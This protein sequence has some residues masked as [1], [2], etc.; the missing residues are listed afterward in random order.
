MKKENVRLKKQ[1]IA[2]VM[3]IIIAINPLLLLFIKKIA[4]KE[5]EQPNNPQP[6]IPATTENKTSPELIDELASN[7]DIDFNEMILPTPNK[8]CTHINDTINNENLY[9]KTIEL[10]NTIRNNSI[11]YINNNKEYTL[12]F[13]DVCDI[14]NEHST[15]QIMIQSIFKDSISDILI[16]GT[17]KDLCVLKDLKVIISYSSEFNNCIEYKK[18]DNLIIIHPNNNWDEIKY[19]IKLELN[20]I[21]ID[22]CNCQDTPLFSYS[23]LNNASIISELYNTNK[24]DL[25]VSNDDI[26]K[27]ALFLT[28]GLFHDNYTVDDYYKTIFNNDIEAL[29]KF[30]GANNEEDIYIIN[31]ILY[32]MN[33]NADY[34]YKADIYSIII[35]NLINYTTNNPK[36]TL[37]ENLTIF[38]SLRNLIESDFS[39]N[40]EELSNKYIKFLSKHYKKTTTYIINTLNDNNITNY[41]IAL[42]NVCHEHNDGNIEI[43]YLNQANKL[44]KTFPLL[45]NILTLYNYQNNNNSLSNPFILSKTRNI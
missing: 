35:N 17:S 21:R 42:Y 44:L 12:G 24:T 43:R 5:A 16:N 3:S 38:N 26:K 32:A 9:N 13:L 41:T 28:L 37:K 20:K 6:I 4:N 2:Y 23:T 8:K 33:T 11:E 7:L 27:E 36:F 45:K 40:I 31:K 19:A 18:E 39:Q 22:N 10:I 30:C 25:F 34:N 29:Y 14:D 1:I 15:D